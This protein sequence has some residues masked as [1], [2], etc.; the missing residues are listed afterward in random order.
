M[1]HLEINKNNLWR[2]RIWQPRSFDMENAI[3]T[4]GSGIG[5]GRAPGK[6]KMTSRH[7]F[8][9][10]S[11]RFSTRTPTGSQDLVDLDGMLSIGLK[12]HRKR[13]IW[14]G[15]SRSR[16]A[17][18]LFLQVDASYPPPTRYKQQTWNRPSENVFLLK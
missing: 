2:T 10:F 14:D 8:W 5:F 6:P 15:L 13:D 18:Y 11:F 17:I 9:Q 4:C 3:L 7:P 12:T 16:P 1:L